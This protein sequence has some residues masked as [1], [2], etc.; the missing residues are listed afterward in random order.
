MSTGSLAGLL[1]AA[2]RV[3]TI[4]VGEVA[5][6]FVDRE[7]LRAIG[8]EVSTPGGARRFVPWVA[9]RQVNGAIRVDSSLLIVD[10]SAS[11]ERL[12]ARVMRD[13]VSL[14]R[15]RAETGG[16]LESVDAVSTVAVLGTNER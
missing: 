14:G 4:R 1:G 15:L 6:V 3:G 12:G 9:A 5:G 13:V 11:Y 8:L 7:E 2:V 16:T 10:D